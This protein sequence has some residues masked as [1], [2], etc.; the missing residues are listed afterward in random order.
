[1]RPLM[2]R[3]ELGDVVPLVVVAGGELACRLWLV[4]SK[5]A[6]GC[7][8]FVLELL[9]QR[10]GEEGAAD[11]V[12]AAD[13]GVGKA[14]TDDVEEAYILSI[15]FPRP[16]G[17]Q[18]HSEAHTVFVYEAQDL[19]SECLFA[20]RFVQLGQIQCFE[21]CIIH[22]FL[23]SVSCSSFIQSMKI[24]YAPYIAPSSPGDTR[25]RRDRH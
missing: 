15:S 4:P 16:G 1:M 11:G 6:L 8:T 10:Q 18:R 25:T 24:K 21:V 22:C 14:V 3:C 2:L 19:L 17:E 23:K 7:V 20:A 12:L 5:V 9:F 13:F